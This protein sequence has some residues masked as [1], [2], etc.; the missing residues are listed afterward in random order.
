[1]HLMYSIVKV[2]NHRRAAGPAAGLLCDCGHPKSARV[3]S[4]SRPRR[5]P[6][7]LPIA[8]IVLRGRRGTA[9]RVLL[10]VRVRCCRH[11][12]P[13]GC[14]DHCRREAPPQELRAHPVEGLAIRGRRHA[15]VQA[16][17]QSSRRHDLRLRVEGADRLVRLP[18]IDALGGKL[19]GQRPGTAL[20]RSPP[21]QPARK[22]R[23][24]EVPK[25]RES[26]YGAV[27]RAVCKASPAQLANQLQ[28]RVGTPAEEPEAN[29]EGLGRGGPYAVAAPLRPKRRPAPKTPPW[30]LRGPRPPRSTAGAP[31]E[32]PWP[33][34]RAPW[35]RSPRPG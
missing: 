16:F 24:V 23:V 27:D 1:M 4:N 25:L 31:P 7:G 21:H 9:C 6:K 32:H 19:G 8:V 26:G 14:S 22:R 35:P 33:P 13:A 20:G 11:D 3:G 29:S 2:R 28:A 18:S 10:L 15:R 5:R 34:S 17:R 30:H 12:R